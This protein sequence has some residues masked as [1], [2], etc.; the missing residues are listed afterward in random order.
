MAEAYRVA[1]LEIVAQAAALGR[2]PS[3]PPAGEPVGPT[4]RA[5]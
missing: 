2:A 1:A 4:I 5:A 3:A